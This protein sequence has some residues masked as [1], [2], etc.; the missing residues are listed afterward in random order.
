MPGVE[1]ANPESVLLKPL[2]A[3]TLPGIPMPNAPAANPLRPVLI[4]SALDGWSIVLV[5]GAGTLLSF[6]F[7]SWIG[8]VVGALI[9]L[10]GVIEL[11]GRARLK[12]EDARGITLLVG[13]QLMI[14]LT[15]VVYSA[16]NLVRFD[17]SALLAQLAPYLP[18]IN[19]ALARAN[20]PPSEVDIRALVKPAYFAVY[21]GVI[22]LTTL[23]QGGL[24]LFYR[25]YRRKIAPPLP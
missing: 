23:F 12:R 19:Q 18:Q 4:M 7:A 25:S 15:L 10:A 5:A 24:A 22:V 17:E 2:A 20:I 14:L 8:V 1:P 21:C 3:P 16:A 6:A 11:R 13:A 9:T